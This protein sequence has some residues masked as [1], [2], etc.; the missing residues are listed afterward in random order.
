MLLRPRKGCMILII[1]WKSPSKVNRLQAF[2]LVVLRS[3]LLL[4]LFRATSTNTGLFVLCLRVSFLTPAP[5][6]PA[7][8]EKAYNNVCSVN[9]KHMST[10]WTSQT[11][12]FPW[13]FQVSAPHLL[14][15][16]YFLYSF[17]LPCQLY[18]CVWQMPMKEEMSFQRQT[19]LTL[20]HGS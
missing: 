18:L 5:Q 1:K 14:N 19:H 4:L 12:L 9:G 8:S 15:G 2:M 17:P 10:V 6:C 20:I 7:G 16:T 11:W 13:H 3:Y